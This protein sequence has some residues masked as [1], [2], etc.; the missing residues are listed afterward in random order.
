MPVRT[1]RVSS[2]E[3][4]RATLRTVWTKASPGTWTRSPSGSGKGGKSSERSVRMW[5][6]RGAAD[7]LHVLLGRTQLERDV[8]AGQRADDVDDEPRRQDDGALA[9]DLALERHAQADLHVGRAQLDP[10]LGREDLDAGQRLDRAAGG[11]RARDR[12]AAGRRARRAGS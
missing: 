10:A 8:G 2:R 11:R 1:G 3:A 9:D 6:V 5:K 12:L 4:E 7:D